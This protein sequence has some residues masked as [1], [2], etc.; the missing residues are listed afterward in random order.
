MTIYCEF[1]KESF[2]K[3][4]I[5]FHSFTGCDTVS[6]FSGKGKI[7]PLKIMVGD[8]KYINAFSRLGE[9]TV[10]SKDLF[11]IIETFVCQMYGWKKSDSVNDIIYQIFCQS[12]G[13]IPCEQLPP[14]ENILKLHIL[15]ANYQAFIWRECLV[16][17]QTVIDP[18]E[19]GWTIGVDDNNLEIKWM[20]CNTAPDE[21]MLNFNICEYAL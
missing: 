12:G 14:C 4:L 10:I 5:G 17:C 11:Q 19:N 2:M 15:R 1:S 9:C 21:V 13:K 18:K 6:S 3:S 7:K 16:R 8:P 20:E